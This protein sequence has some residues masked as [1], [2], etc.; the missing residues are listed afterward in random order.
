MN[1]DEYFMEKALKLAKKGIGK[2]NPN[3]IVGAVVVKNGKIIGKGYHK[4]YGGPHAEVYAIDEAGED[5]MG[6]DIYVTLE[7]CSH[8]GKT[9]PC[10]EKIIK[11][12]IKKCI[13]AVR[14]PNPLV[15]GNGIKK[16]KEAGVEV[17][18]GIKIKQSIK[19]NMPFFKYITTK[20]PYIFLKVG[21]TLDGKIASPS[22][23]SKWITNEKAREKVQKLRNKYM[24][25][26][27]GVNTANKD[28]PSLT[29]RIKNGRNPFRIIIDSELKIDTELKIIK[30]NNDEKTIIVTSKKNKGIGKAELLEKN[31]VKI[32][33]ID[34][35]YFKMDDIITEI[36]KNGIDSVLVEGGS[37]IITN[38]FKENIIDEGLI[39]IAPKIMGSSRAIPFIEGRE[40]ENMTD[41]L[42]LNLKKI[43]IYNDNIGIWFGGEIKFLQD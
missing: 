10:S 9:P 21:I 29:A 25:I 37:E 33:Y 19:L 1:N 11:A 20:K 30:E 3:P 15:A 12:G 14:D 8:Y 16:L 31:K 17:V 5:A 24:A 35:D 42:N 18:E 2:T 39:F 6:A 43:K 36:G 23:E 38:C 28:N 27:I 4:Y 22:G 7:P 34:G 26:L 40:V 32:I 41:I 13:I